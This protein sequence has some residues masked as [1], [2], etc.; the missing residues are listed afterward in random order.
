LNSTTDPA[1][2]PDLDGASAPATSHD[3]I[4]LGVGAVM[5][6]HSINEATARVALAQVAMRFQV[7]ASAVAQAVLTL[8][9]GTDEPLG[10]GAVR[11]AEQLLVQGFTDSP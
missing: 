11:A 2:T 10:D 1:S 7:P 3:V 6:L 4:A 5:A 9:A 8:V